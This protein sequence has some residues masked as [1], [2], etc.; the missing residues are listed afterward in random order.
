MFVDITVIVTFYNREKYL[1]ACLESL[2]N[3]TYADFKALLLDDG[4]TDRSR[5]I[6]ESFCKADNRF[7]LLG[8]EHI[9]FPKSKNL[10][11]DNVT[12]KYVTFLDSDDI[13][14]PD[15][16]NHMHSIAKLT[17]SD[18]TACGYER[19]YDV[20]IDHVHASL[21]RKRSMSFSYHDWDKMNLLLAS[22]CKVFM[23]NKLFNSK[24]FD[25]LRFEDVIALSDLRLIGKLFDRANYVTFIEAPLIFYRK[26][27]ASIGAVTMSMGI[28]YWRYRFE[29][30]VKT[31]MP[32]W[33][34]Y[35]Q[36]RAKIKRIL[37]AELNLVEKRIGIEGKEEL[38]KLPF[39]KMALE[40]DLNFPD[41][42]V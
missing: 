38:S 32:I 15:W 7:A 2:Q 8:K 17:N 16:L 36:T 11:L 31:Y 20:T 40:S 34:K 5:S 24:L 29:S 37:N 18:I 3:Q 26:H 14:H 33:D 41:I 19:F 4:S 25:G 1:N 35:Q 23:W 10:G 22:K 12:T 28:D 39:V 30:F 13:A 9:G 42:I 27:D 6:A 21:K